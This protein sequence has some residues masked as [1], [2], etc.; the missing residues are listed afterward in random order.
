MTNFTTRFWSH[1]DKTETC[2][3]WAGATT[4][5]NGYGK[6]TSGGKQQVAHRVSY[7]M[8]T[9][10]T[11]PDGMFV[12]HICSNRLCVRP[13]HLRIVTRKQNSEH[14]TGPYKGN[15]TG[16]RGVEPRGDRFRASVRHNKKLYYL[17]TFDTPEEANEVA[18]AKRLEL[19]THND[20]DTA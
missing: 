10:E 8:L 20:K 19:F 11:I 9:G 2:W 6:I 1:V 4:G 5:R 14:L 17:G 18:V 15:Q 12:D 7:E 3:N 13:D 16:Y